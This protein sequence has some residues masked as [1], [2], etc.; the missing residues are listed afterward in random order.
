MFLLST[1]FQVGMFNRMLQNAG[2]LEKVTEFKVDAQELKSLE[3]Y[4]KDALSR[5]KIIKEV[6][7]CV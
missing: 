3:D 7:M 1:N 6:T 2:I 4:F 5:L